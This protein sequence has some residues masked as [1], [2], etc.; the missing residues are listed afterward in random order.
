[1]ALLS[2]EIAL[3]KTFS[4]VRA[5]SFIESQRMSVLDLNVFHGTNYIFR[6]VILS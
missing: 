5:A 6:A 3:F 4:W 2:L 1:M